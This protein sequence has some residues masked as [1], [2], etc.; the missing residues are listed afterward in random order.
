MRQQLKQLQELVQ[1]YKDDFA[2][3]TA[4]AT[5]L[6]SCAEYIATLAEQPHELRNYARQCA[7]YYRQQRNDDFFNA[8]EGREIFRLIAD[9]Y[10]EIYSH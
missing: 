6:V 8:P 10:Y 9:A 3:P 1:Q 2:L 5:L 7:E 4:E